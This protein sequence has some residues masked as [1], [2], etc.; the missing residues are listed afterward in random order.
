MHVKLND[1]VMV[2][3]GKHKGET[4]T[5]IQVLPKKNRVVIENLNI[6]KKHQKAGQ[7]TESGIVAFEAPIHASNVL[8]LDPKTNKPTRVGYKIDKN[9]KKVRVAK[10]SGEILD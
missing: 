5:V 7:G 8:P 1:T 3:A 6:V 2:I 4:G 9:G 10:A